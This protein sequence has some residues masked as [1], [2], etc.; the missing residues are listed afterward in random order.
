[1]ENARRLTEKLQLLKDTPDSYDLYEETAV[2]ADVILKTEP[3]LLHSFYTYMMA[4]Q[5]EILAELFVNAFREIPYRQENLYCLH[6]LL[7]EP[8]HKMY[9]DIVH[10]LQAYKDPSS[11]PVLKQTMQMRFPYPESYGTGTKQ[12]INQCRHALLSINTKEAI[13]VIN[14][15]NKSNYIGPPW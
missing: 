9:E 11:I 12:L 1:M 4:A 10:M 15:L 7:T 2:A 8:W 13:D 5:S 14:E 3:E 6:N